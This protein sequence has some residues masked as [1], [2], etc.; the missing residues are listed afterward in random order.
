MERYQKI[1]KLYYWFQTE[2]ETN[3]LLQHV[4][5][6]EE[7]KSFWKSYGAEVEQAC[8]EYW[9]SISHELPTESERFGVSWVVLLASCILLFVSHD[10]ELA[11]LLIIAISISSMCVVIPIYTLLS[12]WIEYKRLSREVG[13][14]KDG[15]MFKGMS[16]LEAIAL[17][18]GF[19]D[20]Q[21]M[22]G[23]EKQQENK[24]E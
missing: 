20:A 5:T 9:A 10:G 14:I 4:E 13:M 6:V 23:R 3:R 15:R 17:T 7:A 21:N 19:I 11:Y 18:N 22:T 2:R 8:N 16:D 12:S 24:K 1:H